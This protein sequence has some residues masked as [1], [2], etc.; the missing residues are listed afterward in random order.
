MCGIAGVMMSGGRPPDPAVLDRLTVALAH[1]GPDGIGRFTLPPVG[2]VHTRLAIVDLETGDQPFY[3]SGG[4]ALVANGEIYNDPELRNQLRGV[5]FATASDCEVPLHLYCR[6]GNA[7]TEALRGMYA[8]A[9]YDP[10]NCHL[11][12]ARDPFGIKPLYYVERPDG[13]AFASEPQ[14]LIA[15]GLANRTLRAHARA[16]LLQLKF[17]TGTATIFSEIHRVLP[18]E[19]LVMAGGRITE[20]S[21]RLPLSEGPPPAAN[22]DDA[23]RQLDK[24]LIDTVEHH[25]R[26]DVPYGLFLSG[27][28]DSSTL[29][30]LMARM[31]AQPLAAFTAGF[32]DSSAADE[33]IDAERVAKAVGAHHHVVGITEHD[34]WN[35]AP[36]VAAALDDPTTDAAAL[37]TYLLAKAA[38]DHVKVVLTGEGGDEIFCGY[39]RYY[40]ARRFWGMFARKARSRGEFDGF[41]RTGEVFGGWRDG[42]KLAED[43]QARADLTF[44][45]TL[46]AVDCAEW[47]PNDLL[48]KVDRCLMAHGLEGRTPFLDPVV[49]DFAFRLPDDMKATTRMA[50]RML[51][52]WLAV[53]VP[54][55]EPYARKLGFNPPVGEWIAARQPLI[56]KLVAAHPGIREIFSNDN[57][58]TSVGWAFADLK[59]RHQAAWSLLFYALWHSHHVLE[60]P[61][62]GTIEDVLADA[63]AAG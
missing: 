5:A 14:A 51:R 56:Q 25:L 3:E 29:A 52:D 20:R 17:T 63:A 30:G 35:E 43:Q 33:S 40:R 58:R 54:A 10:A 48:I 8:I 60:I 47:L 2:L 27:G 55:A 15:A 46:Q 11:T 26:A 19:T 18:G 57:V 59:K 42:L 37:P 41:D 44:V 45:Q 23:L 12:L 9:I 1:R 7:F 49:A 61:S 22:Y 32:P 13:F 50:K 16:E 36:R 38:K 28:I 34:F 24:V 4:A 53:N 39:S 31:A 21:R 62:D 6:D